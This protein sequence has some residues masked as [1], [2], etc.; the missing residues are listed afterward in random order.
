MSG[1]ASTYK[2]RDLHPWPQKVTRVKRV[3]GL[4]GGPYKGRT[5][6]GGAGLENG[7]PQ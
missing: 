5:G 3:Q 1:N 2:G 6:S 7:G 4:R